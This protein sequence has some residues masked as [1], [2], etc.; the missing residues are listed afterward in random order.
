MFAFIAAIC[1]P[2]LIILGIGNFGFADVVGIQI[3]V[4]RGCLV[5]KAIIVAPHRKGAG[6]DEE[7][8]GFCHHAR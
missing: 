8:I 5:R 7:H 2:K 4:V 6:R 1:Q 3:D